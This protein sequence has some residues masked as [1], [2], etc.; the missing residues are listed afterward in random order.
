MGGNIVLAQNPVRACPVSTQLQE[1]LK[2]KTKEEE[3]SERYAWP[4][5]TKSKAILKI[6]FE[7][8]EFFQLCYIGEGMSKAICF[9]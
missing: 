8:L 4:G 5:S 9:S 7:T 1:I 3:E 6:A 2:K